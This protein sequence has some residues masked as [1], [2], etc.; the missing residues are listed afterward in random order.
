MSFRVSRQDCPDCKVETMH[1]KMQ[2]SKC[3]H[4]NKSPT[5]MR[6]TSMRRHITRVIRGDAPAVNPEE[7]NTAKRK[8]AAVRPIHLDDVER[9][10]V[11]RYR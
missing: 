2:C 8:A 4:L 5:E 3:G 11:R 6:Y 9:Y 10:S 7:I 1:V